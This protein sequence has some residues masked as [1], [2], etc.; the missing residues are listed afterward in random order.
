MEPYMIHSQMTD[1]FVEFDSSRR[2]IVEPIHRHALVLDHLMRA[3]DEYK[4]AVVV[5]AGFGAGELLIALAKKC[6]S[7]VAVEPSAGVIAR[8]V[9][10][11]KSDPDFRKIQIVNGNFTR[12]PVD[13]YKADLLVSVDNFDY[14]NSG[15]AIEEFKRALQ[16]GG[17]FF[18]AGVVLPDEDVEGIYDEFVRLVHPLHNDYYCAGDFRTFMALKEFSILADGIERFPLNLR[19]YAA[20]WESFPRDEKCDASKALA[21]IEENRALFT[22]LYALNDT[23]SVSEYYLTGIYK[24]NKPKPET[25]EI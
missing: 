12:F 18:F 13:Y 11:Y 20:Y 5:K 19:E 16:I 15:L 8:F 14:I 7:V 1:T 24:R 21:F 22:E 4:P 23:L 25:A 2:Y 17:V 9:E 6:E 3:V 10:K